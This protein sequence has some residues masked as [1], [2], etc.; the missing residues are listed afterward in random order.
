MKFIP[1]LGAT[2]VFSIFSLLPA[3]A[4]GGYTPPNN[5]H[6]DCNPCL[7]TGTRVAA[8]PSVDCSD[9]RG[10]GRRECQS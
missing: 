8:N 1:S 9:H 7:G 3:L 5:G 10:R 4:E 2:V 6:P